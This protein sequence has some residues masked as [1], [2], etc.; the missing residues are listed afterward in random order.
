MP[1]PKEGHLGILPQRGNEMTACGRIHQ[2][3][4]HQLLISS[5]QVTCTIGLNGHE[6][7]II[8]SLPESP[9]QWHKTNQSKSIYLEIDIPQYLAEELY[10]KTPPIGQHSTIIIASP[11]KATLPEIRRRGQHDHGG[12]EYPISS[13][14]GLIWSQVRD[15]NSEK[16]KPSGCPYTSTS[17]AKGTPSASGHLIP[18]EHLR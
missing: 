5:G 12:K 17:Q 8:T 16:T 14:G 7:S 4:V 10:Q 13:N 6:E 15:P 18:G 3:E 11:H 2:L 9:G 1:L